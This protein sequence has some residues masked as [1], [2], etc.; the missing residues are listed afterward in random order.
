[1]RGLI[2]FL[3]GGSN[4]P[5]TGKCVKSCLVWSFW[6]FS[7]FSVR[8]PLRISLWVGKHSSKGWKLRGARDSPR[9]AVPAVP[10]QRKESL[11]APKGLLP[12]GGGSS[13][14]QNKLPDSD[15]RSSS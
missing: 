11:S 4:E 12:R 13:L 6:E 9:C 8:W 5:R 10:T 15:S 1:M 14:M 2:L 3:G 7:P